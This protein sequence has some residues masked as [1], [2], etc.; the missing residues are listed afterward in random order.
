MNTSTVAPRA[1]TN[2]SNSEEVVDND[3]ICNQ[4]RRSMNQIFGF[5]SNNNKSKSISHAIESIARKSKSQ[6]QRLSVYVCRKNLVE[7][8]MF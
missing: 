6:T 2:S 4:Q 7:F 3:V 5:N 1:A 8:Y